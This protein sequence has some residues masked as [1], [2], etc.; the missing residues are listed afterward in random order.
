MKLTKS[1]KVDLNKPETDIQYDM[2]KCSIVPLDKKS[3]KYLGLEDLIL[4]RKPIQPE[5]DT[6]SVVNIYAIEREEERD[7]FLKDMTNCKL[8]VHGS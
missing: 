8:L 6:F 2:L 1:G 4:N 3:P 7:K 5:T